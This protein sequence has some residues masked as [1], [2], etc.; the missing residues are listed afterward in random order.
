MTTLKTDDL[1]QPLALVLFS[2]EFSKL[3][4]CGISLVRSLDILS[5]S[6]PP[7]YDDAARQIQKQIEKGQVLSKTMQA[8]PE[9]FPPFFCLMVRAGEVGAVLEVTL[10][11]A[12]DLMTKE[13]KLSRR[14][15]GEPIF[16]INSSGRAVP[17]DWDNFPPYQKTLTLLLF[18]ETFGLLLASGA[19]ILQTME[20]MAEMLPPV[21]KEAMMQARLAIR[22]GDP[23]RLPFLPRLVQELLAIGEEAGTLDLTLDRAAAIYEH[24]LDCR[25]L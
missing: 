16:L 8:M 19:P 2:Y 14:G 20:V 18:C 17:D 12:A 11:R 13:W 23:M 3:I 4:D 7:P 10:Q 15:E 24:E 1:P 9:L 22:N 25:M 6:V 5:E 21:Q